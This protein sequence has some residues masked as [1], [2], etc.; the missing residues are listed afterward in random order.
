MQEMLKKKKNFR[1]GREVSVGSNVLIN[2]CD[3]LQ[4]KNVVC[5]STTDRMQA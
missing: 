3:I 1:I 2:L 4:F 5:R